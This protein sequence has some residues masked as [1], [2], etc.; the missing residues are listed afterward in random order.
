[1]RNV[2]IFQ[3]SIK[4]MQHLHLIT[5]FSDNKIRLGRV[6]IVQCRI[7]KQAI[8]FNMLLQKNN[9]IYLMCV[10]TQKVNTLAI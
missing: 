4:N 7:Q 8:L 2:H 5:I 9:K 10:T 3:V 6:C 1:M